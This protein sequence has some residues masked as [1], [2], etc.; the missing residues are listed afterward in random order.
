MHSIIPKPITEYDL[1]LLRIFKVVVE[2]GGF[3]AAENDLG[4]TRSTISVHMSNLESRMKL[5]LCLRG[6]GGFSLTQE[7]QAVYHATL[8][9]FDSID[10]FS[11]FIGTL[12][13]ELSGELVLLCSDLLDSNIQLKMAQVIAY[14]NEKSPSLHVVLDRDTIPN[15]EKQLLKDKAHVGIFPSYNPIE[16]LNYHELL[17]EPIYLCCGKSHAFF[18]KVDHEISSDMLAQAPAI[19]PGIDIDVEGREQLKKL[20]LAAKAYQFDTRKAMILSGCYVGYLPQSHI[21]AELN[22][23]EIRIIQP[24]TLTYP[25]NLSMAFKKLPKE[26]AKIELLTDAFNRVFLK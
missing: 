13:K 24:S 2:N 22:S 10:D 26:N 15:I 1:R 23:G 17:S 14:I 7:G 8:N 18:D 21:Q 6:R 20:N 16:G 25:F 9:L 12:G 11:L 3:A 4:V 19:H 5:K